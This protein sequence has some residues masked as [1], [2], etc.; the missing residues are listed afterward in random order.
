MRK[1]QTYP[2]EFEI[3][4][5]RLLQTSDKSGADIARELGVRRNLD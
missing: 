2:K 5:V 1:R 4:A 3:E